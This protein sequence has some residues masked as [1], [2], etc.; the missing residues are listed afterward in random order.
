MT[1]TDDQN[2]FP[3]ID[4][5]GHYGVYRRAGAGKIVES[6]L[7]GDAAVVEARAKR[8]GVRYTV[9]SPL[10]GLLPRGEADAVAGNDEAAK[11]VDR[12]DGLLQWVIVNPLQP[13]T[14]DQASR[15]LAGPRCVGIKIHPEEHSYP[16]RDHGERLFEFAAEHEAVVLAH[17]GDANSEPID[18]L[19]FADAHPPVRLILAHLG[20]G[21]AGSGPMDKQVQ[22]IQASRHGNIYT[23]TSSSRSMVSG[24]IEWAVREIGADRI[25]FGTDTPLYS[26]AAQKSRILG[27]EI[28]P[29]QQQLILHSNAERILNLPQVAAL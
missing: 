24:L 5:H 8:A 23:D 2:R 11:V 1:V 17:S 28:E 16:I 27:A 25:L 3:A 29:E 19:S 15:M 13:A 10:L 22:A 21:G 20:N 9:V 4:V 14:Y 18:F 26:V 6:C 7:T 12:Y